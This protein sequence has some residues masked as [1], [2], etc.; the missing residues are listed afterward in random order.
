MVGYVGEFVRMQ[1]HVERVQ[2]AADY[3]YREIGLEVDAV[4]PHE[5]GDPIAGPMPPC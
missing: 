3:G 5:R 4:I 2:H 1:P